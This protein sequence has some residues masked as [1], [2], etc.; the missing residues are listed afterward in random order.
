MAMIFCG[1]LILDLSDIYL[2]KVGQ[3]N[4]RLQQFMIAARIFA[5]LFQMYDLINIPRNCK[6]IKLKKKWDYPLEYGRYKR[7]DLFSY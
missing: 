2:Y 7:S 1:S 3:T 6:S 4:R 5:Y